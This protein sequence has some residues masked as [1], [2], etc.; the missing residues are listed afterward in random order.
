M[1]NDLYGIILEDYAPDFDTED[2]SL[3]YSTANLNKVR[4]IDDLLDSLAVAALMSWMAGELIALSEISYKDFIR[5][6]FNP[7]KPSVGGQI[8]FMYDEFV[9]GGYLDSLSRQEQAKL[10]IK[11]YVLSSVG[12]EKNYTDFVRGFRNL[13]KGD[14]GI[15]QKYY[16]SYATDVFAQVVRVSDLQIANELE[17]NHFV[18]SGGLIETSRQF[19]IK[20]D[21]KIFSRADAETWRDDP[22]LPGRDS[23]FAYTPLVDCGRYRCR[24]WLEWI[25]EED[26]DKGRGDSTGG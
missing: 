7:V 24:H 19:C 26:Y 12:A 25:T 14:N 6:G 1:Q 17:L 21:G 9:R 8:G 13:I 10:S 15:L 20:K 2:G 4:R 22:D 18:Y 5:R 16:D 3:T 23:A 11:N